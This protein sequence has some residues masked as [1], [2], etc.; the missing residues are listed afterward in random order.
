MTALA[1]KLAVIGGSGLY[2]LPQFEQEQVLEQDTP[3]GAPSGP[4]RIGQLYGQRV[5]FL[6]RHGEA[7]ALPPHRVNYRANLHVLAQLQPAAVLAINTV[8][9]ITPACAPR[10]LAG[11]GPITIRTLTDTSIH[12]RLQRRR[13]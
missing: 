13:H 4:I 5:A 11:P 7:H 12:D 2:A 1:I 3:Y 6:A 10:A 9:G 8:G